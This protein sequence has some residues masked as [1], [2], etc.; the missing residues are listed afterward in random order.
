MTKLQLCNKYSNLKKIESSSDTLRSRRE[1]P[2][3]QY[4]LTPLGPHHYGRTL[5]ARLSDGS[6][7]K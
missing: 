5:S 4:V 6:K 1:V 3:Q 7:I 2:K